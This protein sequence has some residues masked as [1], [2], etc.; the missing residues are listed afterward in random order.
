VAERLRPGNQGA[1]TGDLVVLDGLRCTDDGGIQ[2]FLVA[3]FAS[4]L[5]AFLDQTVNGRAFDALRLLA[6]LLE[7]LVETLDLLLRLFEMVLETLGQVT[8]RGFVDQFRQRLND[9]V[10]GVVDVLQTVEQEVVH[11]LDFFAE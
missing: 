9:L 3:N 1:V 11:V 7:R 10:L 5:I 4:D 2:N 8:V 6:K